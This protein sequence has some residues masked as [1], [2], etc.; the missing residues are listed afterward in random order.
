MIECSFESS[1][2]ELSVTTLIEAGLQKVFL[3]PRLA[4]FEGRDWGFKNQRE[5]NY[6]EHWGAGNGKKIESRFC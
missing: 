1:E 3:D 6:G 2:E 5:R 4:S